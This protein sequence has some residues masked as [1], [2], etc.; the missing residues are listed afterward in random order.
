VTAQ[1]VEQK[2]TRRPLARHGFSSR[3]FSILLALLADA[4]LILLLLEKNWIAPTA[5]V[6]PFWVEQFVAFAIYCALQLWTLAYQTGRGDELAATVDK[7]FAA[8]PAIV[9][10]LIQMYW[11]GHDAAASLS[12]RQHVVSALWSAF[13][14]ADFFATDITNQRLRMRQ[15]NLAPPPD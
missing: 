1:P 13:A 5:E 4:N 12:W 15:L 6:E 3:S 9:T 14:I 7:I 10:S 2:T 11:V 8:S